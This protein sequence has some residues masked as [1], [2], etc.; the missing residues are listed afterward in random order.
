MW[1]DN[2]LIEIH[3]S[4]YHAG[5]CFSQCRIQIS[6]I[7]GEMGVAKEKLGVVLRINTLVVPC[8][9]LASDLTYIQNPSCQKFGGGVTVTAPV[10][11]LATPLVLATSSKEINEM[12]F[13]LITFH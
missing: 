9:I 7:G 5:D 6:N 13:R 10:P 8:D 3:P 2:Y 12:P 4:D 1:F 11:S